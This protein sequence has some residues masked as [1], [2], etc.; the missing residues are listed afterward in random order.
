MTTRVTSRDVQ[1]I[2]NKLSSDK[3][4]LR[5]EGIKLLNTW[6]EGERSVGFCKYLSEK[7][8]MLK[9]NEIPNSETWPFLV[10]LLIQCVSLEISLSKKRLP[11][12]SLGKT[13]RIVVQRAEDD[14]FAG[15]W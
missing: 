5:D 4:K 10:K 9:P 1:E 11:K 12:L 15:Q 7:T 3:A 13:L 6:L 2:V 8:A 14:R